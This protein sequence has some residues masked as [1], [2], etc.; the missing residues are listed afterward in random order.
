MQGS[1]IA[2]ERGTRVL[3]TSRALAAVI[4][5]FLVVAW[6]ILYLL[7]GRTEQLFA[8]P[9]S[10]SMTAMMLGGTY[11]GGAYFF[12]RAVTA[13]SWDEIALG[14]LPV[15]GFATLMGIA[16]ILHW[17]KFTSGHVSFY[18][19]VALYFTTPFLV[20]AAWWANQRQVAGPAGADGGDVALSER[21]RVI[22]GA[23]GAVAL[24][25]SLALFIWPQQ[26]ID[27]WPWTLSP[28]TGRVMAAI[29]ALGGAG[30][31]IARD[32]RWRAVRLLVQVVWVMLGLFAVAVVLAWDELD[33]GNPLTWVIVAWL[34]AVLAGSVVLHGRMDRAR[35]TS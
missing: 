20:L 1:R 29:F 28:L 34:V 26:L 12:V 25:V 27:V 15:T 24:A 31:G 30:I 22:A 6:G 10:P 2:E 18:V 23:L 4:V 35:S 5:P 14:F 17:D 9:V 19:W 3:P 16:T 33:R 8:W 11:L 21:A 32:P 13:R 7:P